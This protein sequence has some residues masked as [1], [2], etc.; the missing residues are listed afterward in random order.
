VRHDAL[1]YRENRLVFSIFVS[2]STHRTARGRAGGEGDFAHREGDAEVPH[3]MTSSVAPAAH[4]VARQQHLDARGD[5][6]RTVDRALHQVLAEL[7]MA[8]CARTQ[9]LGD[10][11]GGAGGGAPGRWDAPHELYRRRLAGIDADCDRSVQRADSG[12]QIRSALERRLW[13]RESILSE[14][15]AELREITGCTE[16]PPE[17]R[18]AALDEPGAFAA[19]VVDEGE[20]FPAAEVA[21]RF[22]T[23]LTLVRRF[24][25]EAGREPDHGRLPVDDAGQDHRTRAAELVAQGMTQRQ[26]A[27]VLGVGQA[28]VHRLL[29]R[30]AA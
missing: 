18:S 15:R 20:G 24:R 26:I 22:R 9:R 14:A 13:L 7:E 16:G 11:R 17:L 12:R 1:L 2:H 10:L 8:S 6:E 5:R 27:M 28:T 30:R 25:A 23:S 3:P 19:M 4:A 29:R 21:L